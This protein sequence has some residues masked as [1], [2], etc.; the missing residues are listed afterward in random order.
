MKDLKRIIKIIHRKNNGYKLCAC[1][2]IDII[3]KILALSWL[4]RFSFHKKYH[5]TYLNTFCMWILVLTKLLHNSKIKFSG[6][7]ISMWP[8]H[9]LFW[10][11]VKELIEKGLV[12]LYQ[13]W[14]DICK[15]C[16]DWTR[17][18]CLLFDKFW[19]VNPNKKWKNIFYKICNVKNFPDIHNNYF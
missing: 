5:K 17:F 2:L 6:N 3:K 10:N 18:S 13:T 16:F 8:L 1:E 14:M 11:L 9:L 15:T 12:I 19:F 7:D 4:K